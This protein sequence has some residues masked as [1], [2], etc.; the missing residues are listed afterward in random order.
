[1][2]SWVLDQDLTQ[3]QL[4]RLN[5]SDRPSKKLPAVIC[6]APLVMSSVDISTVTVTPFVPGGS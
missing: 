3:P 4:T 6:K 2:R 5:S 1:M